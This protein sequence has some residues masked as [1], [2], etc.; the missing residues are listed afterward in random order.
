MET[1][2]ELMGLASVFYFL[3]ILNKVLPTYLSTYIRQV[4]IPYRIE[5]FHFR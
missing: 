4:I 1:S 2:L 5:S 3:L